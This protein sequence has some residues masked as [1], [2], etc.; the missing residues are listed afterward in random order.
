MIVL[1]VILGI[2]VIIMLLALVVSREM[3]YEKTISIN[4]TVEKV[5]NN[6]K[7]LSALDRWSPWNDKDPNMQ[8][9]TTGID[10]EVGSSQSWVSNVKGVG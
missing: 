5:W 3:N 9:T 1:Y 7:S 10:G 2:I 6:V 8:K 4:A